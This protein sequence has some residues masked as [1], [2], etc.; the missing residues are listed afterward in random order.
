MLENA[1][2]FLKYVLQFFN[3]MQNIM[4]EVPII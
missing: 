2:R 3:I 4:M 1:A